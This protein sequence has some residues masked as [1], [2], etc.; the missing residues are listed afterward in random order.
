M[1]E[2]AL[3]SAKLFFAGKLFKDPTQALRLLAVGIAVG[4]LVVLACGFAAPLWVAA[5]IGGAVAGA[6]QPIL[7]KSLK[8]N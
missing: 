8:F 1:F 5:F 4:A 6:L 7:Y 2:M 3:N